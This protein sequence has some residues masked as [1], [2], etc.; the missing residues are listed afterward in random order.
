METSCIRLFLHCYKHLR[1]GYYCYYY[2]EMES[3]SVTQTGVQWCNL[4]C[5]LGS[6]YSPTSA[7]LVLGLQVA[8]MG[9]RHIGH[10]GLELL[11][12]G[13][14]PTLASQSAGITGMSHHTWPIVLDFEP[15]IF[16]DEN[17][18]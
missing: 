18:C 15:G 13:D 8:E 6:S 14:P 7:F 5:L 3:H 4:C 12:S 2:F 16:V 11:T 9:F 1:L 10:V 17:I